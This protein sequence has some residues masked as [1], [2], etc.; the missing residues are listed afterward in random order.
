[1]AKPPAEPTNLSEKAY[2]HILSEILDARLAA[3]TPI[4]ERR[5]AEEI[6]VSRSP[7]RDAL[8]RLAGEGLLVR[9][10]T[11]VLAVRALSLQDYLQTLEMR[12]LVEPAAVAAADVARLETDMARL[13][14]TDDLQ[15]PDLLRF[16]DDLHALIASHCGNPF[17]MR[18]LQDMRRYTTLYERQTKW[19]ATLH[20][21]NGEHREILTAL[22]LR[23][24]EQAADAMRRHLSGIRR[25][26]LERF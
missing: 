26:V 1:M 17:M 19:R 11:G 5:I 14:T 9:S 15:E 7:L 24:P 8:G 2:R 4:Q 20:V 18:Y 10:N 13:E 21:D 25:R 16:D 23:A 22:A 6:G 3:G 12:A